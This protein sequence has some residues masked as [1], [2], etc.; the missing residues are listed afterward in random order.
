MF[1]IPVDLFI[2]NPH[3]KRDQADAGPD[4]YVGAADHGLMVCGHPQL[5]FRHKLKL[6]FKFPRRREPVPA[7]ELLEQ[8][9]IESDA[10]VGF[11][12]CDKPRALEP[13]E[14]AR[15]AIVSRL[16]HDRLRLDIGR[17]IAEGVADGLQ[18]RR[19]AVAAGAVAKKRAVFPR[20]P[21]Q[22]V[23]D[24]LLNKVDQVRVAVENVDQKL[25]PQRMIDLVG[26]LAVRDF[27]D[28]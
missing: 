16:D 27:G 28:V 11:R 15:R 21:G 13:C 24:G 4:A 22:G 17:V 7:G 14:V 19:F 9:L 12:A 10:V 25:V 23:S 26:V 20:A 18:K 6:I 2:R 5:K 1:E 8:A 3:G